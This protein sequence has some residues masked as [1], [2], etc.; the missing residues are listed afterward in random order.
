MQWKDLRPDYAGISSRPRAVA[1]SGSKSFALDAIPT[2]IVGALEPVRDK[3]RADTAYPILRQ[4][5]LAL[6]IIAGVFLFIS[7]L[8][9]FNSDTRLLGVAGIAASLGSAFST[10]ILGVLLDIADAALRKIE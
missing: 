4:C 8:A 1:V 7:I 2:R 5:V 10:S 3:L 9:L 6:L